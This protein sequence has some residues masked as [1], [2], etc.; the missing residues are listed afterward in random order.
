VS[1]RGVKAHAGTVAAV[2]G[3][4]AAQCE[5]PAQAE[6]VT[7]AGSAADDESAAARSALLQA[8]RPIRSFV[9]R[10][11]RLSPAQDR[12]CRELM[13]LYGIEYAPRALDLDAAFGRRAPVVLEIGFGMGET[14]AAIAAARPD[15]SFLGIEVHG[16]GVGALLARIDAQSL[17]NVRVIRHDA[18]EVVTHMLAPASL[19]GVHVFFPDPWPK[20][21]HHKRRLLQPAFVHLLAERLVPGGYLHTATD[22]EEYAHAMLATLSAEPL[23]A[24][25]VR[26]FAPRPATRPLTKFE[27]RGARLGHGTWDLVFRRT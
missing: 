16:P 11:G 13:P 20:K 23:L 17:A 19:A 4:A 25:T 6:S 24:N 8:H 18:V 10:Q 5:P 2:G 27:A 14:T 15:T 3:E 26:D 22:W 7:R 21:R 9:L 1:A 12:A